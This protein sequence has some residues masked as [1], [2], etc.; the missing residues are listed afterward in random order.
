MIA[1]NSRAS[2]KASDRGPVKG[3]YVFSAHIN[4]SLTLR[5]LEERHADVV[6]HLLTQNR[7]H[8]QTELEWLS[9]PFAL[10]DVQAYIRA[11]LDRFAANNGLRAGIWTHNQFA[12][13]VSLHS[14]VWADR[15][16]SLGYWLGATFQ[17]RGLVSQACQHVLNHAFHELQLQRV[18]IQCG[19]DNQR[20]RKIAERLGFTYEGTIRQSWWS[21]ERFVDMAIYG[22]LAAEWRERAA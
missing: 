19:A 13:I 20:S 12:G 17:G 11:G 4:E 2:L 22:L 5:L 18:E 14:L 15:K 8:L 9:E 10:A 1:G 7:E 6:F 21:Q 3:Y 16:A